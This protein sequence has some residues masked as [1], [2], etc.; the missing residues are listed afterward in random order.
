MA[1]TEFS[2]D[3]DGAQALDAEDEFAGLRRRFHVPKA[4]TRPAIYLCGHSLGLMPRRTR[5]VLDVELDRWAERAVEGHFGAD[6]WLDY[7]ARFSEPLAKLIGAHAGEVV[8]MNTL[9]ANLHLM[10]VSFFR[11]DKVRY[12]IVIE[13]GAFPSDRYAVQSQLQFHGLDPGEAMLEL[14]PA[15]GSGLLN[16]AGLK[17]L[18]DSEGERVALVLLPG[19]QYLTGQALH[20]RAY[21]DIARRFGCRIGFDLAHAIGNVPLAVHDSGTDFAVWC[22]YKYLNGGPGAVAGCFVHERWANA[23]DL[24]RFAGWWGHDKQSRLRMATEFSAIPGAEGWQL[25]NPPVLSLAPLAASLEI[26][27]AAGID[28]LRRKSERLT[29]YL[30]FLLRTEF[31]ERIEILTPSRAADRGCQLSLKLRGPAAAGAAILERLRSSGVIADWRPPNI[32]RFAP[33][34]LYNSYCDVFEAV[35]ALKRALG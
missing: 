6:G 10:L 3:P 12:K 5:E 19:V 30:E 32:V 27:A 31:G 2:P 18:L 16:P 13:R 21:S 17:K 35:R 11:P 29:A 34:P 8:A 9:T 4:G 20:L 15:P 28:R 23:R 14:A 1:S 24:P 22:S 25:S 33:V 7:H 26:F